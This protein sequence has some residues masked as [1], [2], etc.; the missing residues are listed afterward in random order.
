MAKRDP[1]KTA[2]NERIKDM[3]E[4]LRKLLPIVLKETGFADEASL[5]AK[6]DGKADEF[7]DL[8]NEVIHSPTNYAAKYLEGF[9]RH[10]SKGKERIRRTVRRF[11]RLVALDDG[12]EVRRLVV[13]HRQRI[14]AVF[15]RVELLCSP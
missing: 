3:K 2:R 4:Q 8:K 6:I 7:I 1:A 9:A 12:D 5:N 11:E 15:A 10:C 14:E 13:R